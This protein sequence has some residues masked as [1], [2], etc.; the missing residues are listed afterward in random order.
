MPTVANTSG[1]PEPWPPAGFIFS[2]FAK[3]PPQPEVKAPATSCPAP[4]SPL[5]GLGHLSLSPHAMRPEL[6]IEMQLFSSLKNTYMSWG[7]SETRGSLWPCSGLCPPLSQRTLGP[8]PTHEGQALVSLGTEL[9]S[10]M[11]GLLPANWHCH[12]TPPMYYLRRSR[13]CHGFWQQLEGFGPPAS[14]QQH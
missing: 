7:N 2:T 8:H 9:W 14:V 4:T 11:K 1:T 6:T 5:G 13:R 3:L 12:L 10:T